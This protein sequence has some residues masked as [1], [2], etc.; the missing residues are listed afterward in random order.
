MKR[1]T[2]A[3]AVLSLTALPALFAQTAAKSSAII[4]ANP[5]VSTQTLL[6]GA[7]RVVIPQSSI[8]H[9]FDAGLRAHT[10]FKIL[11]PSG[12]T[13]GVSGFSAAESAS[14]IGKLATQPV[15]GYYAETPA[16]LAC[17]Y[18]VVTVT[19]GCN[20]ASVTTVATGG[21]RA[22]AI[23][24]AYHYPTALADLTVYSRQFGLPAPTASTFTVAYQGS[25]MP[26]V[27]PDCSYYGGW[28]CW[29][30]EA[31]LD[32]EMAHAMAPSAH[33]YLVEA[34]S[35][36]NSDLFA[37]VTKAVT[38]VQAAGG[39]EVSMSWGGS[40]F[41]GEAA[42][43]SKLTGSNVVFFASTGDSE[44]TNYPSVSPNVVAVGG[45]TLSRNPST[46]SFEGETAWED[47]GGGYSI[48]EARPAFQ[49]SIS[50]LVSTHRGVPDV[51]AVGNP[52]TGVW[53]YMSYDNTSEG[54]LYAWNIFGGTSVA[55]P[56]WAGIVNHAGHFSA[57]TAT[58]QTLIYA[59]AKTTTAYRDVSYGTCGYY[60]G[61][62]AV[63][64]WDPCSGNGAPLGTVGK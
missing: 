8:A 24:D 34:N 6:S 5:G 52:R 44:G 15:S 62:S 19:S 26:S 39:G 63:S 54:T 45:T 10:H 37:A 33:V 41:Y 9:T 50:A 43:D 23:V 27:D 7:G 25:T 58:E 46:L 59:N 32:I 49:S 22:I 60:E 13:E 1:S 40:E 29:A 57:S 56:L 53:V 64:G 17:L 20:M 61:W 18:N 21:S 31:A 55:A 11:V 48:Y 51:S 3:T 4:P 42:Y 14:K 30:A 28:D 38:L 16:S 47:T 2:L 12:Q 36:S 35:S